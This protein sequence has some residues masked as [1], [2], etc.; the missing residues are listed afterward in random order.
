[1]SDKHKDLEAVSP[2]GGA[3]G[4]VSVL[5]AGTRVRRGRD[6]KWGDQ[7]GGV[8]CVGSVT[9]DQKPGDPWVKITWDNGHSNSYRYGEGPHIDLE[10]VSSSPAV[11]TLAPAAPM[12]APPVQPVSL[13]G[14][15][16]VIRGPTWKWDEQDGGAGKLG[17]VKKDQTPGVCSLCFIFLFLTFPY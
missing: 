2:L 3:P 12:R 10:I 15:M 4:V 6:W 9:V 1:M 11:P 13:L 7:D 14:G 16:R 5:T 8:G 17:V